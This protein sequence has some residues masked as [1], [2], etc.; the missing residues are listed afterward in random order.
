[1]CWYSCT[2]LL[3]HVLWCVGCRMDTILSTTSIT[4]VWL[5]LTHISTYYLST[6]CV[7]LFLPKFITL[8]ALYCLSPHLC[9]IYMYSLFMST[10]STYVSTYVHFYQHIYYLILLSTTTLYIISPAHFCALSL[11]VHSLVHVHNMHSCLY[12]CAQHVQ[13]FVL[14]FS[15]TTVSPY[16]ILFLYHVTI[17]NV[18]LYAMSFINIWSYGVSQISQ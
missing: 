4:V 11:H 18:L 9:A 7:H 2:G 16:I 6:Y 3:I 17:S 15:A 1:M 8:L 13:S 10:T 5:C 12:I 14:R